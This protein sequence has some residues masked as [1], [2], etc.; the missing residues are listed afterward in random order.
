MLCSDF[1]HSEGTDAPL[2]DYEARGL[3]A[4]SAPALYR[5]NIGFLLG[6]EASTVAAPAARREGGWLATEEQRAAVN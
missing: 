1:P 6:G 3:D 4:D 5:D 2:P